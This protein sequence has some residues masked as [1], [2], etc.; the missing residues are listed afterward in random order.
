MCG[1]VTRKILV[2]GIFLHWGLVNVRFRVRWGVMW[3]GTHDG[4][5]FRILDYNGWTTDFVVICRNW[6]IF[7]WWVIIDVRVVWKWRTT[8]FVV[9]CLS[10]GEPCWRGGWQVCRW[11]IGKVVVLTCLSRDWRT[12]RG[13]LGCVI[14]PRFGVS[15]LFYCWGG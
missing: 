13:V 1:I 12:Y 8:N 10:L 14:I 4:H 6:R 3:R 15:L 7:Y 11:I 5:I 2:K 9:I